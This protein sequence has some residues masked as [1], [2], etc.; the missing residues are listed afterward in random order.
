MTQQGLIA[1][2]ALYLMGKYKVKSTSQE[3]TTMKYLLTN[4]D[5]LR[6]QVFIPSDE[7][8]ILQAMKD[9]QKICFRIRRDKTR[10]NISMVS[11]CHE[12]GIN[13]SVPGY[14]LH[15]KKEKYSNH[16]SVKFKLLKTQGFAALVSYLTEVANQHYSEYSINT[17]EIQTNY[18]KFPEYEQELQTLE[19]QLSA[20]S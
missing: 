1:I 14:K 7:N 5:N 9:E 20:L 4:T 16:I 15:E 12:Q 6:L 10:L 18:Y 8:V 17:I 13:R 19:E 3:N 11:G 2:I